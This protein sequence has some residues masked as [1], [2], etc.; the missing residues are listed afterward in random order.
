MT[1]LTT[2]FTN[3]TLAENLRFRENNNVACI[4]NAIVPISDKHPYKVLYVLEM[5]NSTNKLIGIGV[6]TKKIWPREQIYSDPSYNRYTYKG[7]KHIPASLLPETMVQELEEKLFYGRGHLKRGKSF[8][9]FPDKW[10]KPE[11][12][13]FMEK[14]NSIGSK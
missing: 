5:N 11:Y 6:I 3:E 10:L 2:R 14:I 8:T 13:D 1:F 9:Q 4:Y 7:C 12:F